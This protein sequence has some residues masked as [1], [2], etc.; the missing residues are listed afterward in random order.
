MSKNVVENFERQKDFQ[1]RLKIIE[2]QCIE[3]TKTIKKGLL[4]G[5]VIKMPNK[6]IMDI[7]K[8]RFIILK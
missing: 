4:E 1:R 5:C 6:N 8:Y 2:S 3:A 7:Y